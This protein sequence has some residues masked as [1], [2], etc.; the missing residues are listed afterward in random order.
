MERLY[1]FWSW[2]LLPAHLQL[3][4]PKV[5][6]WQL[7]ANAGAA[8]ATA[9]TGTVQASPWTTVRREAWLPVMRSSAARSR[10]SRLVM[11]ISPQCVIENGTHP[12]FWIREQRT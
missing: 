5:K 2:S 10:G 12:K 1:P 3:A 9:T 6:V 8:L 11:A 7:V 4:P